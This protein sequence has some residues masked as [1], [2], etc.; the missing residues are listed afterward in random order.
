MREPITKE[1]LAAADLAAKW[2]L[3]D[4]EPGGSLDLMDAVYTIAGLGSQH[5][6]LTPTQCAMAGALAVAKILA[7]VPADSIVNPVAQVA[8]P[9]QA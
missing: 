2:A 8:V 6:G 1:I 3:F 4:Y 5:N 9:I 7:S